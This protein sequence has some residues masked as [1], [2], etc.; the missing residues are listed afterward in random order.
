MKQIII[1]NSVSDAKKELFN[2]IQ[3]NRQ[4]L[5]IAPTGTGKTYFSIESLS[6]LFPDYQIQMFCP[7]TSIVEQTAEKH[8]I[9]AV[10]KYTTGN[11]LANAKCSK[12]LV[13]TY[14]GAEQLQNPDRPFILVLDEYHSFINSCD[15][16]S[17]A[18]EYVEN[19]IQ[20]AAKIIYLT[21]TPPPF[22]KGIESVQIIQ[23]NPM[24]KDVVINT[25]GLS[26]K[27]LSDLIKIE[28]EQNPD[29]KHLVRI[30]SKSKIKKFANEL[31]K[32]GIPTAQIFNHSSDNELENIQK[33]EIISDKIKVVLCTSK[34]ETGVN[35]KNSG[36]W[37]VH[38]VANGSEPDN[39]IQFINRLRKPDYLTAF[40]HGKLS[41]ESKSDVEIQIAAERI[42]NKNSYLIAQA[43]QETSDSNGINNFHSFGCKA[44]GKIKTL[45]EI[46]KTVF[47]MFGLEGFVNYIKRYDSG[48]QITI[49]GFERGKDL[50]ENQSAKNKEWLKTAQEQDL[51]SLIEIAVKHF[52]RFEYKKDFLIPTGNKLSESAEKVNQLNISVEML[53]A[54]VVQL[55]KLNISMKDIASM[56]LDNYSPDKWHNLIIKCKLNTGLQ[57]ST[58]EAEFDRKT[59]LKIQSMKF[60]SNKAYTSNDLHR[61]LIKHVGNRLK[62]ITKQKAV[63]LLKAF[64]NLQAKRTNSGNVYT[65]EPE[66][67]P[68]QQPEQQ[69]EQQPAENTPQT[70]DNKQGTGGDAI[71]I[72]TNSESEHYRC[73][74]NISI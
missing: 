68:E 62:A 40:Y 9:P 20:K 69:T 23:E 74:P 47:V 55:K 36:K 43:Q 10:F 52:S 41:I 64:F 51:E 26:F 25:N 45:S 29:V 65:I 39:F 1:K 61:E 53:A 32:I 57:G 70:L 35:V 46:R 17:N 33:N 4:L 16:R 56:I 66:P 38:F 27:N 73:K 2:S 22:T 8:K 15:Y 37:Q 7:L 44:S 24:K 58:K 13:S 60:E 48:A 34:V 72:I 42:F 3:D 5:I 19:L 54:K 21:A 71:I 12:V 14:D 49:N 50:I 67:Q 6:H 28:L 31:K 30:Q 59:L 63:Q 11:E 18:I